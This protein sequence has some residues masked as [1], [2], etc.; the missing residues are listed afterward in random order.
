[1]KRLTHSSWH[2]QQKNCSSPAHGGADAAVACGS[3]VSHRAD[4]RV[5]VPLS[6]GDPDALD[7]GLED[8]AALLVTLV[9]RVGRL[10]PLLAEDESRAPRAGTRWGA[11]A[12]VRTQMTPSASVV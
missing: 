6:D 5:Q 2:S 3:G 12:R 9:S 10:V 7:E 8:A 11:R 1:M 4:A